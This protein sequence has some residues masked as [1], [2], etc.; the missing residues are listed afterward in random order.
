MSWPSWVTR[1]RPC[2]CAGALHKTGWLA[3]IDEFACAVVAA[4]KL[5]RQS[6]DGRFDRLRKTADRKQQLILSWFDSRCFSGLIT[7]F[8]LHGIYNPQSEVVVALANLKEGA[9]KPK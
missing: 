4:P 7:E 8:Q 3:T 9:E 5:V 1:T 6:A 2:V